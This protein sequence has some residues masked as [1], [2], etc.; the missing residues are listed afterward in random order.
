MKFLSAILVVMLSTIVSLWAVPAKPGIVVVEEPDGS[1]LKIYING[2][3][4]FRWRTTEDGYPITQ[5]DDGYYYY[6]QYSS[7]G[8]LTQTTQRVSINGRIQAPPTSSMLAAQMIQSIAQSSSA[9]QRITRS[10]ESRSNTSS[11]GFPSEGSIKSVVILAEYSDLEFVIENPNEAFYNQ[12][13]LEGYSVEGATGSAKDYFTANS[14]GKFD[15]QF[16]VYGPYKLGN[17]RSYYGA[18]DSSG[19]DMRPDQMILDAVNLADA[20]GV[21]FS[22]YDFDNDGYIDNVF[23]YYAGHN[24]AEGASAETIWPHKWVVSSAPEFDGKHLYVYACTSELRGSKGSIIAGIGTFCHEFS[25]V[26]GLAD[27][28]DTNGSVGGSGDGLG[29]YD[30]MSVGSYNNNGNTPPMLNGLELDMI[31]WNAPTIIDSNQ[32]IT[33]DPIHQ[34][35]VYKVLTEV[36][37]EYFL[38]ENRQKDAIV[39]DNYI[40]GEG[41]FIT[42]V[43]RSSDYISKW[44]SNEPNGNTSHECFKFV[45]AGNKTFSIDNESIVPYPYNGNDSWSSYSTPAALSWAGETLGVGITNIVQNSDGTITLKAIAP[46]IV[47]GNVTNSADE[48]IEAAEV[49][50]YPTITGDDGQ[51][52]YSVVTNSSGEFEV[53]VVEGEYSITITRPLYFDYLG[54]LYIGA[55]ESTLNFELIKYSEVIDSLELQVGQTEV[56][57]VWNPRDYTTFSVTLLDQEQ[58]TEALALKECKYTFTNLTPGSNYTLKIGARKDSESGDYT[59][60]YSSEFTTLEQLTSLPLIQLENYLYTE[61]VNIELKCLNTSSSDTLSWFIDGVELQNNIISPSKGEYTIQVVVQRGD[62]RYRAY[63]VINIE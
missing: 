30:I 40:S 34:G 10:A 11:S 60:I 41:L 48:P 50:L 59:N 46:S 20:D 24:E 58:T 43:D 38:L 33:I 21:D 23:V 5:D 44:T 7:T 61:G 12:L 25:H 27:H 56:D 45:V 53:E 62:A 36:D 31:G 55:G 32:T 63:R 51:D 18:N 6:A 49:V 22:Q 28:Y 19:Y 16:D 29:Y 15:G 42:H 13:N 39:W 54:D 9:Q 57:A 1:E 8:E 35:E 17:T 4:N 47:K 2:D 52:S 14:R 26:F 3:E 37:G